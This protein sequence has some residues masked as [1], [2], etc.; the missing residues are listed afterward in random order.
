VAFHLLSGGLLLAMFF[1]AADF[2]TRPI[3]V[4]GQAVFAAGCGVLTILIRLYL[5]APGAPFLFVTSGAYLAVLAMN[6]MTPL[7]D[8]V[9]QPRPFGR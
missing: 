8:R 2:V 3:T 1:F 6:T 9:F 4:A 7:I 5:F